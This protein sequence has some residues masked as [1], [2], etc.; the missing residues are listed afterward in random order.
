MN[1]NQKSVSFSLDDILNDQRIQRLFLEKTSCALQLWILHIEGEDFVENKIVYGRLLPY[2]FYNNSWSFSDNDKTK[3]FDG[4]RAQ[5]KKLNIYLDGSTAKCVIKK[6]CSGKTIRVISDL[7]GLRF[8]QN[9]IDELFGDTKLSHDELL[10]KPSAYL[11]NQDAHSLGSI[12]SPHGSAGAIS[13]S[14]VQCN[15]QGL[16]TAQGNYNV[17]LSSMV[18]DDLNQ[19]TG[20]KFEGRDL[21]RFGEIELMVLPSIDD[22]EKSLKRINWTDDKK[23]VRVSIYPQEFLQ[24]THFQ[25]NLRIENNGQLLY[26]SLKTANQDGFGKYECTFKLDAKLHSITDSKY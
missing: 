2:N 16:L 20:F 17:D 12:G 14:I 21:T 11:I 19:D 25:L 5:V 15:K 10:F 1:K 24:C 13:A 8:G 23:E 9:K 22:Q 18:I 7:C 4:Y 6:F 3:A 26:S